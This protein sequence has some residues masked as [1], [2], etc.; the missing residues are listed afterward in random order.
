[1]FK[2]ESIYINPSGKYSLPKSMTNIY[3]VYKN[4]NAKDL[5]LKA[6]KAESEEERAKLFEA[7]GEYEIV[8]ETPKKYTNNR[9]IQFLK[10][11]FSVS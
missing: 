9:L 5:F 10:G 7:M 8:R 4:P 3:R 2:I 1:M 6:Q 11:L